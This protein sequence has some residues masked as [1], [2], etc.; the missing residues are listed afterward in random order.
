MTQ[1][2]HNPNITVPLTDSL[3]KKWLVVYK[4]GFYENSVGFMIWTPRQ[5]FYKFNSILYSSDRL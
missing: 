5:A 3:V 2:I 1:S 4:K